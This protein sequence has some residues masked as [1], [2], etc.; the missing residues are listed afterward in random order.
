ME[1]IIMTEKE[2][3]KLKIGDSVLLHSGLKGKVGFFAKQLRNRSW[4][5][6][7]QKKADGIYFED[8]K[9]LGGTDYVHRRSIQRRL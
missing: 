6:S 4:A 5:A 2:F 8:N 9:K 1:G 7:S 3:R